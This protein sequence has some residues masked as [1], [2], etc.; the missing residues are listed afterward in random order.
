MV[1]KVN[2]SQGAKMLKL[3]N[4]MSVGPPC[5]LDW[6]KLAPKKL[7]KLRVAI[8]LALFTVFAQL[9]EGDKLTQGRDEK[10]C[11]RIPAVTGPQDS[12]EKHLQ[13]I[14]IYSR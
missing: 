7:G 4:L 11:A 6:F 3:D 12:S 8:K 2:S 13:A 10:Q 14:T 9:G 5:S 1:V